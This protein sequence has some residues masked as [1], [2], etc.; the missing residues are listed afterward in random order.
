MESY[1]LQFNED[2]DKRMAEEHKNLNSLELRLLKI[3]YKIKAAW[4][5]FI[6]N[7]LKNN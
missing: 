7:E 6:S 4:D 3:N 1:L 2:T 5:D